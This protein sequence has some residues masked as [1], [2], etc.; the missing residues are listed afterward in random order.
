MKKQYADDITFISPPP[1]KQIKPVFDNMKQQVFSLSLSLHFP[2]SRTCMI[3]NSS[4]NSSFNVKMSIQEDMHNEAQLPDYHCGTARLESFEN[5]SG[6]QQPKYM[7]AAGFYYLGK[8]DTVKCFECGVEVCKWKPTDNP[9]VEHV[10]VAPR[11]NFIRGRFC[12]NVPRI[13]LFDTCGTNLSPSEKLLCR[14]CYTNKIQIIFVPCQ[15]IVCCNK[16]SRDINRCPI[17]QEWIN[18]KIPVLLKKRVA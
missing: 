11:C 17:C 1:M 3:E 13:Q 7:A 10:N 16:C 8:K 14:K 5:W 2:H 15:H 6:Q 4:K 9:W 12:G 18:M